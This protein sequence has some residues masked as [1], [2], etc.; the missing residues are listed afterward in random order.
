[1]QL[2]CENIW[3][4]CHDHC[5]CSKIIRTPQNYS[6]CLLLRVWWLL[7]ELFLFKLTGLMVPFLELLNVTQQGISFHQKNVYIATNGTS[8]WQKSI[9]QRANKTARGKLPCSQYSQ[10]LI[11]CLV[12]KLQTKKQWIYITDIF[13]K[14]PLSI[15]FN[16]FPNFFPKFEFP[17]LECSLSLTAAYTLVFTVNEMFSR[18]NN[19]ALLRQRLDCDAKSLQITFHSICTAPFHTAHM[20]PNCF[21][22][23]LDLIHG[24]ISKLFFNMSS[25]F[26]SI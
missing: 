9:P 14:T 8:L 15:Y 12:T 24:S 4:P 23:I 13:L 26:S 10:L 11:N 6:V 1:M 5:L 21:V 3:R 17:N 19:S 18:I 2:I 20:S 22:F 16:F 7:Q 25:P